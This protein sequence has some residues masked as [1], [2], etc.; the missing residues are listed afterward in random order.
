[1]IIDFIN[2][3]FSPFFG[4]NVLLNFS[5]LVEKIGSLQS[6]YHFLSPDLLVSFMFHLAFAF[7][8]LYFVF[9]LPFRVIKYILRVPDKKGKKNG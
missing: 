2:I 9:I 5:S 3:L 4:E 6:W 8:M 7:G 1:M